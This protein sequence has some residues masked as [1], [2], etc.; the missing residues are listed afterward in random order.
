MP[1]DKVSVAKGLRDLYGLHDLTDDDKLIDAVHKAAFPDMPDRER[2]LESM[3][4]ALFETQHVLPETTVQSKPVGTV[5][6]LGMAGKEF[7]KQLATDAL[8][9]PLGLGQGIATGMSPLANLDATIAAGLNRPEPRGDLVTEEQVK[10]GE[11]TA[12]GTIG[13]GAAFAASAPVAEGA[14]ATALARGAWK[15]VARAVSGASGN[16]IYD[17]MLREVE[18]QHPT[19]GSVAGSAAAGG[20]L[21][22][23]V[24][25][26]LAGLGRMGGAIARVL[27]RRAPGSETIAGDLIDEK[28]AIEAAK[29]TEAEMQALLGHAGPEHVPDGG[30]DWVRWIE[31]RDRE[32]AQ[33][34]FHVERPP[35]A[36][37][38]PLGAARA[39]V[40]VGGGSALPNRLA[41][42]SD[43]Q[44]ARYMASR[45]RLLPPHNPAL[46]IPAD[47]VLGGSGV[48]YDPRS[49]GYVTDD[50]YDDLVNGV[51]PQTS[52][53][54]SPRMSRPPGARVPMAAP[55]RPAAD[56][57]EPVDMPP[58]VGRKRAAEP[59]TPK[60]EATLLQ[61][62]ERDRA[63]HVEI[64]KRLARMSPKARAEAEAAIQRARDMAMTYLQESPPRSVLDYLGTGPRP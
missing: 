15:P 63:H 41:G 51:L 7:A 12:A 23:F 10:Q 11:D 38:V 4:R 25:P 17:A 53:P 58:S 8:G 46:R 30:A 35:E 1:Y 39:P 34:M 20:A 43:A 18:G 56:L 5:E 6:R 42:M 52:E 37:P 19:L 62:I 3:N 22:A 49:G 16:A 44:R 29:Q 48:H 40:V 28:A 31:A 2:F 59:L 13:R 36:P 64:S 21:G 55:R 33:G 57:P 47:P 9:I 14:Y 27:S 24:P 32:A 60:Q 45:G 54:Q 26:V 61:Q 50:A